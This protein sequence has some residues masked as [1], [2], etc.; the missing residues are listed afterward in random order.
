MIPT[1]LQ[2]VSYNIQNGIHAEQIANT[3]Y[4]L[5]RSGVHLFCL[6]EVRKIGDSPFIGDLIKNSLDSNWKAYYYLSDGQEEFDYGV[7]FLWNPTILRMHHI[8]RIALPKREK[9]SIIESLIEKILINR[10]VPV[11]RGAIIGTFTYERKN[12]RVTNVHLDWQGGPNH[13]LDQLKYVQSIINKKQKSTYEIVV[14]DFNTVGLSLSFR[15][16]EQAIK[17]VLGND[18]SSA[19]SQLLPTTNTFFPQRLDYVFVKNLGVTD[20]KILPYPGSDH[21]PL[22]VGISFR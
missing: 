19:F 3:I 12:I 6:Q 14:G 8:D 18:F 1:T 11:S 17:N 2:M 5:A 20:L 10:T 13:R 16:N 22:Q 7:A 21:Y 9:L 15:K 4:K